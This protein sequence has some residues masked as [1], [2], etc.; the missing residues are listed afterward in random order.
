MT[1]VDA[2]G[3]VALEGRAVVAAEYRICCS[4]HEWT[5]EDSLA[6]ARYVLAAAAHI[7]GE[8][9]RKDER[10][11]RLEAALCVSRGWVINGTSSAQARRDLKTVDAALGIRDEAPRGTG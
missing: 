4:P 8:G 1:K 3:L 2:E 10:T 6:M 11:R 5:D 7:A 9:A